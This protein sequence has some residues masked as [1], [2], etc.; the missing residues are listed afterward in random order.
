[1]LF[2]SLFIACSGDDSCSIDSVLDT[3]SPYGV[4]LSFWPD[5]TV[6]G[7]SAPTAEPRMV[8]DFSWTDPDE[9][10]VWI[11]SVSAELG[12]GERTNVASQFSLDASNPEE[13][14]FTYVQNSS[15]C[16]SEFATSGTEKEFYS[17]ILTIDETT[18][19]TGDPLHVA[20]TDYRVP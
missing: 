3:S 13:V 2:F 9:C 5:S 18:G 12:G 19:Q 1:M 20:V 7:T 15:E 10:F 17:N 4:T 16:C 11:R 8:L 14:V 6:E